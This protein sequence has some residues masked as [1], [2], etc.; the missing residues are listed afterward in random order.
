MKWALGKIS[1]Y[2]DSEYEKIYANLS[3]SRKARVD[4]LKIEKD[5]KRSLLGELLIRKLLLEEGIKA[6]VLSDDN[7]KP[8]LSHPSYFISISHSGEMAAA[9]ISKNNVGIDI[10][11]IQDIDLRLIKRVCTDREAEY[12][13]N[14]DDPN[15]SFLEIWTAKEAYFKKQGTGITNLKSVDVLG[16]EKE[17]IIEN[18]YIIQIVY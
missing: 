7:G 11:K 5:R 9:I 6:D 4:R 14:S 17:R 10:E 8:Y 16:I 2:S 15:L 12:V 18:G 1:D 3:K 13:K